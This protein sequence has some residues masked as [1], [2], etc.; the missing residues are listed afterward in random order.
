VGDHVIE[1]ATGTPAIGARAEPSSVDSTD[2]RPLL[3]A[4]TPDTSGFLQAARLGSGNGRVYTLTYQ[5]TDNAGNTATCQATVTV[6]HDQ[7][8]S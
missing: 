2:L 5:G 6:P 3:R 8:K 4:G 7:G 1:E